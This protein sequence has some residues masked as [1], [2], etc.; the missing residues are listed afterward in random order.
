LLQAPAST[1]R[2][3]L[4]ALLLACAAPC[5]AARAA[6]IPQGPP[7]PPTRGQAQIVRSIEIQGA[8]R[9]T[10]EQLLQA[11]GQEV[12]APFDAQ[13]INRGIDTLWKAFKV[14]ADV[15]SRP[16]PDGLELLLVVTE[17]A[18]DLEP[19]FA[20]NRDIDLETLRRWAHLDDKSELYLYQSKRVRQRLLEGYHQEGYPFVEIEVQERG[21]DGTSG[22]TPDVI[23]EIR[24]GPQVR[25]KGIEIRGN[26]SLPE[27]G[28]LWWKDGLAHLAKTDLEAPWLF[29]MRGSKFV[30]ETLQADLLAM[31]DVYRDLGW[32]D[33]VVELDPPLEFS[34][35]RSGVVIHIR[36][37]EGEPYVVSKL[38]I[39]GVTRSMPQ[40]ARRLEDSVETDAPLLFDEK[41]LLALCKL[42]PGKRYKRSEQEA[43][44]QELRKFYGQRGYIWHPTLPELTRF[45]FLEPE[46]L[47]DL[48]GHQVEVTYKL[49]QGTQRW[50]RE[51]LFS[52][53][54]FTR[55]RVLRREVDVLP[56]EVAN[57][58]EINRSLGRIYQTD[59]FSGSPTDADHRDPQIR[60]VTQTDPKWVDLVY[61]VQEGRVVDFMLNGGIDSNNGLVGRLSMRMRNFDA[62][63]TPS[64]V[65]STFSEL[66]DKQAFHGA[67]QELEFVIAPGTLTNQASIHFVEPDLFGTH[68]ERYSLDVGLSTSRRLWDFYTENRD[69]TSLKIG[70]EFGRN[71]TV[72]G[73]IT[74]QLIDISDIETPITGIDPPGS[75]SMPPALAA[76]EGE[77][78]LNGL[79]FDVRYMDVD[80]RLNPYSGLSVDWRNA[81]YGGLLGGD[82]DF[83][84]SQVEFDAFFVPGGREEGTAQSGFHASLGMGF[85][86]PY[87][88]STLVPY[89][90]RFFL[91]GLKSLRGFANRGVGPNIKGQ[92]EGG[93]TMLDGSLE[94][95]IPL[96]TQTEPG[97][98][99]ER[100]MFRFLLFADAGVLDPS[101]HELD[102]GE[103][104]TSVGFGIGM[105]YPLP[106]SL[107]FGFP[108]KSGDGDQRQTFGF[109]ISSFGF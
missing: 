19:R 5:A 61:S 75:P 94:Y 43:D 78:A 42:A 71:L 85:A 12:G 69:R 106:I 26:H 96:T 92:P 48:K 36:V 108:M 100:E 86:D 51:V 56:G 102:F 14:R 22:E 17:M 74:A 87:G 1:L 47:H 65:W 30:E 80:N 70:R 55:D 52:G 67:G 23:F 35:D 107:Y 64:D 82:W 28:A 58:E 29:N 59:Y 32:L 44:K 103:L 20:G 4:A 98:Y 88:D 50:I 101:A 93:E 16:G 31:R 21:G 91:G 9:Y 27:T 25:V 79:T 60:F 49:Q 39:R 90:E 109:S 24:E 99:R 68:L 89:T 97:T 63:N 40:G 81:L 83:V 54:E 15:Q 33:A 95:R 72:Y 7:V 77:S 104:R 34:P 8:Q 62:T 2:A 73:G 84:R 66:Y 6:Q 3:R 41:Q 57:I 45:E 13:Q 37:D 10:R 105:A 18:F 53:S 76:Q 11:L 38:T 46:L